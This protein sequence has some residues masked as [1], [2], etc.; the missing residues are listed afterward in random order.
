[1]N[2]YNE[3]IFN[4]YVNDEYEIFENDD[5]INIDNNYQNMYVVVKDL[6]DYCYKHALPI[7]NK[8][9]TFDIF[10]NSLQ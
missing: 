4:D 10:C 7:F 5:S 1:M 2:N 6:Q 3:D 8:S 9:N